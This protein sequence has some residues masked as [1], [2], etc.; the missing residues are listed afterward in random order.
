MILYRYK[1]RC[2]SDSGSSS[3]KSDYFRRWLRTIR[4]LLYI[5]TANYG[6]EFVGTNPK[7]SRKRLSHRRTHTDN[8]SISRITG[9]LDPFEKRNGH[10]PI[11]T[12]MFGCYIDR[13]S[14]KEA[15]Q[16]TP[17]E[18]RSQRSVDDIGPQASNGSKHIEDP[19]GRIELRFLC[20]LLRS[21]LVGIGNKA[22]R[23]RLINWNSC[24]FQHRSI[25]RRLCIEDKN[26]I[27]D[28]LRF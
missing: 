22:L 26:H 15:C 7:P 10:T 24:F 3:K 4:K 6:L 27:L 11:L 18:R 2:H 16:C 25:Y 13:L 12:G 20:S 23:P 9:L 28:M 5:N 21:F 19:R 8:R 1:S 17:M 14:S